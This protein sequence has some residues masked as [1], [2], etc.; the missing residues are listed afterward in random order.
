[1]QSEVCADASYFDPTLYF[2]C[3][4]GRMFEQDQ[5]V[6]QAGGCADTSPSGMPDGR[7]VS[8]EECTALTAPHCTDCTALMRISNLTE[9]KGSGTCHVEVRFVS[10]WHTEKG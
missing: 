1:M 5:E 9:E 7:L 3:R 2:F 10:S 6:F 8:A 4:S